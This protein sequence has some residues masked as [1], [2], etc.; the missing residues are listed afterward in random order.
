MGRIAGRKSL[1]RERVL[2]L[3]RLGWTNQEIAKHFR[4]RVDIVD[5]YMKRNH[6]PPNEPARED[7]GGTRYG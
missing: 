5:A 2:E 1:N 4:T 7:S 3:W 6:L